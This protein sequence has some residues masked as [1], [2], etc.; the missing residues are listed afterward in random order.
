MSIEF[1]GYDYADPYLRT[2]PRE[3][4]LL[5]P[6]DVPFFA[7]LPDF[8]K[9]LHAQLGREIVFLKAGGKVPD[10][11]LFSC[12]VRMDDPR[13][14]TPKVVGHLVLAPKKAKS[15][16]RTR[17]DEKA[18]Q[19]V[20][21]LAEFLGDA[22]R[23]PYAFLAGEEKAA[24][25]VP[26]PRHVVPEEKFGNTLRELLKAAMRLF[27]GSAAAL[28]LL[29]EA[30][31]TLKLRCVWGLPEERLLEPPRPLH[32]ATADLEAMLGHAVVLNDEF[33][34]ES[35]GTPEAFAT[36]ICIPVA[37][38]A[39]IFGTAWFYIDEERE[40]DRREMGYL[41]LAAGR[42]A[43]EL[44]RRAAV[45]EVHRLHTLFRKSAG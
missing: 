44:E 29:D 16:R 9:A 3:Q 39:T 8:L 34:R 2:F 20:C 42:L 22:Y 35:W 40:I 43:S 19:T 33:A 28:Y 12:P 30:T 4:P 37:S 45:E 11:E 31:R 1:A 24:C 7:G 17:T 26:L 10:P 23:W 15:T 38:E 21:M 5:D 25:C 32:R 6:R 41:E 13:K 14:G 36:S 27:D 18:E